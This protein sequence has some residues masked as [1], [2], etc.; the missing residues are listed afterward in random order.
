VWRCTWRLRSAESSD[1]F[2]DL[3]REN[4]EMH[5][6][7]GIQCVWRYS[8]GPGGHEIGGVHGDGQSGGDRS[9][10]TQLGGSLSGGDES[11][12]GQYGGD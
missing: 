6:R 3:D 1:G 8:W 4:L 12:Y 5:S 2:G 7:V 10:G 11:D 9:G